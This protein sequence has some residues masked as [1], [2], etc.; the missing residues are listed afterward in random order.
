VWKKHFLGFFWFNIVVAQMLDVAVL[1]LLIVPFEA[2]P[3]V[4]CHYRS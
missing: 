3:T 2:I 1:L 4:F